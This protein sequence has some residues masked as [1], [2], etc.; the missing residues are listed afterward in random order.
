MQLYMAPGQLRLVLSD[1]V[2]GRKDPKPTEEPERP[3]ERKANR[4]A[5]HSVNA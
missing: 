2:D 3:G 4:G 5:N 1:I